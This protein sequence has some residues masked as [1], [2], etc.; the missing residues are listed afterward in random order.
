MSKTVDEYKKI[1][2]Y[3]LKELEIH[4]YNAKIEDYTNVSQSIDEL[5]KVRIIEGLRHFVDGLKE[6]ND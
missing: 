6:S 1:A 4:L 5:I 2:E 3:A